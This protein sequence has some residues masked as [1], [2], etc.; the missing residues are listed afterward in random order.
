MNI[1]RADENTP[2]NII[3]QLSE[4][5]KKCVGADGWSVNSFKS[6]IAKENGYVL[7]IAENDKAVALFAGYSAVGEGDITSIAT[8]ENYRRMGL[9]KSLIDEF[10]KLLPQDTE[11]I[12]LEVRESNENAIRLYIKC[13]FEKISVRRN[14]YSNPRENAVVMRKIL[15]KR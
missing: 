4:L 10:E 11:S 8:D 3:I 6:E 9:A 13:G 12:F 7:Y 15:N 2:E 1:I 14:F 5:D